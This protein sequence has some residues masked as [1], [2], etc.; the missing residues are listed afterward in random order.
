MEEVWK[1]IPNYEG[2]HEASNLGRIRSIDREIVYSDGRVFRLKSRVLRLSN[3]G[4]GYKVVKIQKS[5]KYVHQMVAMAF[6]GHV[7]NGHKLVV[8]HIDE[9]K[10]NNN[11]NNLRI[12]SNRENL[13]RRGG[14]SKYVGVYFSKSTNKWASK[15][16]VGRKEIWIGRFKNEIDAHNAYQNKLKELSNE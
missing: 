2:S 13:S 3:G 8:D 14:S 10:L 4:G 5:V 6:L 12:V 16:K 1:A 15:I 7:P 9:D 11:L